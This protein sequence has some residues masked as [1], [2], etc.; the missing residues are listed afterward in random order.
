MFDFV[1]KHK[2]L[3]QFILLLLIVPP[4]A[5]WGIQWYERGRIGTSDVAEVDGSKITSYD[6]SRAQDEQ[7]DQLAG[8]LGRN[9][10][11]AMLDTP[12][13]RKH[14]LDTLIT[15]RVINAYL[16]RAQMGISN[17][18]VR[19]AIAAQ[20]EFQE[21]GKFSFGRYQ[22]LVRAGRMTEDDFE[23]RKR[24]ELQLRQL[25]TGLVESTIASKSVARR[26]ITLRGQQREVSESLL[27]ADEFL[28]Q[29]KLPEHAVEQYYEKNPKDFEAPEQ[30]RVEYVVLTLDALAAQEQISQEEVKQYYESSLAPRQRERAQARQ[31]A[32][33]LLAQV[34]K[35]PTKFAE[36]A[37]AK[38][39]DSGSA[40]QGG[41]LGWFGRGALV[42]PFEDMAFKLKENEIS[43]LVA[44][45]FGFHII[46][47]TGIRKQKGGKGEERRASHILINAP[48][49]AKDFDAAR[50]DIERDF[51]R[52]RATEKFPQF[53]VNVSNFADDQSD[54]LQPVAEKF[55]LKLSTTEWFARQSVPA[56]LNSAKLVATLFSDD[57]I[58]SKRNSEAVE[59]APGTVVV[60]RVLEHKPAATRPLAEVRAAITKKLMEEEALRRAEEAGAARLKSLA[61]GQV[62]PDV[63]WGPPRTVS[64]EN[65]AG[66]D[67]RAAR[68]VFAADA[69]KPPVYL[70]VSL[71]PTGYAIYRISKVTAAQGVDDAKLRASELTLARQE[72]QEASNAFITS[73]RNR[74]KVEINEANLVKKGN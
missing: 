54:S 72:A 71:A 39:Q 24:T 43:P 17:E 28:T 33:A 30:I 15:Q 47:V 44:T 35:D 1:T 14:L 61:A 13:A 62:P 56:P 6:F 10:D 60:A 69:S 52:Q 36:I 67:P 11:P 29:V 31:E 41:D 42:K 73:L 16:A 58:R 48:A 2:R 65:P 27:R 53:V 63:K 32:E 46:K 55:K 4:F 57:S 66:L 18:Q 68:A 20:P 50:A 64:R 38:S 34:R 40:A 45:E 7:R 5:F 74:A 8:V 59:T 9:F 51:K 49:E 37:K 25:N 19:A 70:G 22:A 3:L 26:V 21:E 23:A 12:Q